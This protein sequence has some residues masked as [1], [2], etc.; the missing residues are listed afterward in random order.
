M[1]QVGKETMMEADMDIDSDVEGQERESKRV[2]ETSLEE[3]GEDAEQDG[4][5][6]LYNFNI[7]I[8]V[9]ETETDEVDAEFI[10][11]LIEIEGKKSF[12]CAKCDKVCKSKGGLTRHTNSKHSGAG[13]VGSGEITNETALCEDTVASIVESIKTKLIEEDLYG[14]EINTGLCNVSSSEN[15]FKALLPLYNIF[16][17]KKNQDKL[18]ESFYGLI[19]RSCELLNC[20]DYRVTNLVMFKLVGRLHMNRHPHENLTLLN[21]D[22]FHTSQGTLS[23]NCI[24][25]VEGRRINATKNCKHCY[26][27]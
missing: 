24:K 17:R 15:L 9:T 14:A 8:A 12:P 26:R 13:A 25:H 27:T 3:E 19:P 5:C 6:D 7:S 1:G 22:L 16:C 18:L 20:Q 11:A 2:I 10:D 23:L 4:V 21:V